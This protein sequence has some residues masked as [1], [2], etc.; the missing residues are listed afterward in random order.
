MH[1]NQI[2]TQLTDEITANKYDFLAFEPIKL[3]EVNDL[4]S[5]LAAQYDDI[6][7]IGFGASS[8]N[9]RAL[10]SLL[11]TP[12]KKIIYLDT[13]DPLE[14][15][16]IL[17]QINLPRSIFFALSKSGNTHETY[18]LTKYLLTVKTIKTA[19]IYVISPASNNLLFNLA[20]RCGLNHLPHNFG[21]SG[22]FG[23]ILAAALLPTIM[24]GLD[25]AK[26]IA[27]ARQSLAEILLNQGREVKQIARWYLDNY[28]AGRRIMVV[29]NYCYQLDGLCRWQQQ[30]IAESLGKNNFGIT[31]IIARG[32]FDEH[33]QL[34]LYL[35]GPDDKFYQIIT[36]ARQDTVIFPHH[37]NVYKALTFHQRPV[38]L[39]QLGLINEQLITGKIIK[40]MLVVMMIAKYQQFN[41]FDQPAVD[42]CKVKIL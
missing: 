18:L 19:S 27:A 20:Q 16:Q 8:L 29:L 9:I 34:Q 2:F 22:R 26:I 35:E 36:L 30:L 4:A 25:A 28:Y 41:P 1:L 33:S 23:I 38:I 31:P 3:Q 5:Q 39:E 14:I 6:C 17:S 11:A 24:A 40:L 10:L 32:T 13:V 42:R 15:S 37:D 12:S 7:V 21:S